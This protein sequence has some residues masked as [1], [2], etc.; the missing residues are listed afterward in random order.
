MSM[1]WIVLS[2][3]GFLLALI[4]APTFAWRCDHGHVNTGDSTS[5]VRKKCGPPDYVYSNTGIYRHSRFAAIDELW[6]YNYGPRL[7]LQEL[8]FH[9]GKL[10]AVDTP[11]Y[12]FSSGSKRC[13]PQD[14][15]VGMSAYA[16]ASRCGRPKSKRNR[17]TRIDGG[18]GSVGKR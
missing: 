3:G 16:L 10:E 1:K 14:P 8:R 7:L 2:A 9:F 11:S 5:Q 6:Y 4:M 18:K 15:R 12:G 13:A 17:Y